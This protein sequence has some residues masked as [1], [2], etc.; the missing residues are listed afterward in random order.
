MV[1]AGAARG[2]E[3]GAI[4]ENNNMKN[5]SLYSEKQPYLLSTG[6][7]ALFSMY[8]GLVGAMKRSIGQR[9]M[10]CN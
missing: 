10:S 9:R 1:A 4:I 6:L 7:I 8:E 5:D 2:A 3:S